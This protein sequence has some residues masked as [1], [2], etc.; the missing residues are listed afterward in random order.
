MR[1][2][3]A[4]DPRVSTELLVLVNVAYLP[5]TEPALNLIQGDPDHY[6]KR[7]SMERIAEEGY[8]L[9]ISR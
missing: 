5:L 4:D 8:N 6:A 7:V 1:R 3:F 2:R 9:N